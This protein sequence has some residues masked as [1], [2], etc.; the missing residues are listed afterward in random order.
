MYVGGERQVESYQ[1]ADQSDE[2]DDDKTY[3]I[4]LFD[5]HPPV[6]EYAA[7]YYTDHGEPVQLNA[8]QLFILHNF[9]VKDLFQYVL[10]SQKCFH[11]SYKP[12]ERP[13]MA[14]SPHFRFEKRMADSHHSPDAEP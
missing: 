7:G 1:I 6:G 2:P 10:G 11:Q 14:V 9:F 4:I 12:Q 8:Y 5:V 3:I 13:V